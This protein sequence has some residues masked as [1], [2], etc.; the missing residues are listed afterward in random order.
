[1]KTGKSNE[2]RK[3]RSRHYKCNRILAT[4]KCHNT[5][6]NEKGVRNKYELTK[7]KVNITTQLELY[8]KCHCGKREMHFKIRFYSHNNIKMT[9]EMHDKM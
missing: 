9:L 4:T 2:G 5:A 7:L 1:M 8:L 3:Q 6:T